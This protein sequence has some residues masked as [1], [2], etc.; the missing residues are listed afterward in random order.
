MPSSKV[1]G[2]SPSNRSGAYPEEMVARMRPRVSAGS[3]PLDPA[4]HSPPL[5]PGSPARCMPVAARSLDTRAAISAPSIV[6]SGTC[7]DRCGATSADFLM[8]PNSAAFA[9]RPT[10][11]PARRSFGPRG[12]AALGTPIAA[13]NTAF[14]IPPFSDVSQPR[15]L[16]PPSRS[17]S[18]TSSSFAAWRA[19]ASHCS[20]WFLIA[21]ALACFENRSGSMS[22]AAASNC[23][24]P[25][26]GSLNRALNSGVFATRF[27]TST[28][29]IEIAPA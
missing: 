23:A 5:D 26:V 6:S 25:S 16:H 1:A 15:K 8:S 10:S 28:C 2:A 18:V 14:T 9:H 17:T 19:S 4:A 11:A 27:T 29:D 13:V 20:G 21:H 22:F 7:T 12:S 24:S 3:P